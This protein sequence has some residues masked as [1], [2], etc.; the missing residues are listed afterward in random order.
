MTS[1]NLHV[2]WKGGQRVTKGRKAA[3]PAFFAVIF[4]S[5][6]AGLPGPCRPTDGTPTTIRQNHMLGGV[7][8]SHVLGEGGGWPCWG[9]RCYRPW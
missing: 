1:L 4:F 5:A 6:P 2:T 9:S 3:D 8:A 7:S